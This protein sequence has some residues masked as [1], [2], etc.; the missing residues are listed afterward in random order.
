MYP[1]LITIFYKESADTVGGYLYGADGRCDEMGFGRVNAFNAVWMV[2][3][4]TFYQ[5]HNLN[6]DVGDVTGCDVV[7]KDVYLFNNSLLRV[8]ARN[9]VLIERNLYINNDGSELDI[10]PY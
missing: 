7:I 8:R 4:T 5:V 2:C 1:Q 9:N 6:E 10:K 3:D